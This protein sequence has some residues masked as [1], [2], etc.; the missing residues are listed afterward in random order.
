ME[1]STQH[2]LILELIHV[3]K[4]MQSTCI[5]SAMIH[6]SHSNAERL[7]LCYLCWKNLDVKLLVYGH[8]KLCRIEAE[9]Y[10]A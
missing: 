7:Q 10:Q 5:V 2:H 8:V 6:L 1:M 9:F 4:Y 3:L